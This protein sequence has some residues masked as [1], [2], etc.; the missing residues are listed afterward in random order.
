M[1]YVSNPTWVMIGLVF[2]ILLQWIAVRG[3][4]EKV[5]I[6][7]EKCGKLSKT[8]KA[9]DE[10]SKDLVKINNEIEKVIR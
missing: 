8:L 10:M 4:K 5:R 9:V 6:I 7:D 2:I 3:W 1:Y